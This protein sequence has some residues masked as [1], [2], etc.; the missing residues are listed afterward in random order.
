M[1]LNA[2]LCAC[3]GVGNAGAV[4]YEPSPWAPM[5]V[6]A[7]GGGTRW[8]TL[9][10]LF[11]SAE[12]G[13]GGTVYDI[14]SGQKTVV[15]SGSIN[16]LAAAGGAWAVSSNLGYRD[17]YGTHQPE[18]VPVDVDDLTGDVA[19]ILQ[20]STGY[21]LGVTHGTGLII[22]SPVSA[23]LNGFGGSF[24]QGILWYRQGNTF[25][26]WTRS[27]GSVELDTFPIATT[28]WG[29]ADRG[30]LQ[31]YRSDVGYVVFPIWPV[32][33][34]SRAIVVSRGYNYNPVFR[35]GP[36]N[37]LVMVSSSG[38]GE[39]PGELQRYVIDLTAQTVNGTPWVMVDLTKPPQPE[40]EPPNPNPEPEPEPPLPQPEPEPEPMA[41]TTISKAQ[42][43]TNSDAG[44]VVA[45]ETPHQDAGFIGIQVEVSPGTW[46]WRF[47][48]DDGTVED[49]RDG[50]GSGERFV[51]GQSG[52]VIAP[53]GNKAYVFAVQ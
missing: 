30:W 40:P 47:V 48:G 15:D 52:T 2:N 11:Y 39:L 8:L 4:A 44:F 41:F 21:G 18:W 20:G 31:G 10:S 26:V 45:R 53:R 28:S 16:A 35:V 51:K 36:N 34:P 1:D 49:N 24:R 17:S 9:S 37:T 32:F 6:V 43:L 42:L 29:F 25:S 14:P 22:I 19:V 33:D 12:N 27:T 38:A 5:P 46:K 7:S 13:G 3:M 50:A 23:H